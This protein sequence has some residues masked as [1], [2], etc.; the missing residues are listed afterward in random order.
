MEYVFDHDVQ[1]GSS[2]INWRPWVPGLLATEDRGPR[3]FARL[4]QVQR[5]LQT[6]LPAFF[7]CQCFIAYRERS[8]RILEKVS[9]DLIFLVKHDLWERGYR[10][11]L[12]LT[13]C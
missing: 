3:D 7:D 1:L 9:I 10:E 8:E 2:E 5:C 4:C 11:I 6:D 13:N 12:E